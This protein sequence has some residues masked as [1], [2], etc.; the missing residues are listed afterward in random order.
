MINI[1][2]SSKYIFKEIITEDFQVQQEDIKFNSKKDVHSDRLP[3][4]TI[5]ID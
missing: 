2:Q 1:C 4:I 5:L 3:A